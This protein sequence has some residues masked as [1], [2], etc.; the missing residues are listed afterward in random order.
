MLTVC[1]AV[2]MRTEARIRLPA[3]LDE[4]KGIEGHPTL[5]P[6]PEL[7]CARPVP[8]PATPPALSVM[9]KALVAVIELT[10]VT[11]TVKLLVATTVGVPEI[12]PVV[13]AGAIR[14][15]GG[16]SDI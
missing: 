5:T 1:V 4:R 10:S 6:R 12:V 11:C 16:A 7:A 9:L 15:G 8:L 3:A 13:V 2:D 14:G